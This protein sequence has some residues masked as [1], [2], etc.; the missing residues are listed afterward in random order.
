MSEMTRSVKI[1]VD[2]GVQ[3]RDRGRKGRNKLQEGASRRV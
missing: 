3:A 1:G 2:Y